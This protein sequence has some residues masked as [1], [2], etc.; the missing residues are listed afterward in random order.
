MLTE[1]NF[2]RV[3][4]S[5]LINLAHIK[6]YNKGKGGYVRMTDNSEIEVSS[7]RK[8]EFLKRTAAG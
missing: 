5:H 6:E 8:S 3:H 1:Y 4:N 7:R 2:F